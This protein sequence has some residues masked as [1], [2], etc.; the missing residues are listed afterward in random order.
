MAPVTGPEAAQR[1]GEVLTASDAERLIA[2]L[3]RR[4]PLSYAAQEVDPTRRV[5]AEQLC[6]SIIDDAPDRVSGTGQLVLVLHALVAALAREKT[7]TPVWTVPSGIGITGAAT[8][9]LADHVRGARASIVCSTFNLQ[10][11]SALVAALRA[12][13]PDSGVK[14]N[15]FVDTAAAEGKPWIGKNGQEVAPYTPEELVEALPGANVWRTRR[16]GDRVIR[17]HAKFVAIDH[18]KLVVTSANM[19][20]SA[21]RHNVELGL[22]AVDRLLTQQVERTLFEFRSSVYELVTL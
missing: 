7:V 5:A 3:R 19:S 4:K 14:I 13:D 2:A 6:R 20:R 16:V 11:S 1:L 21:E 18:Q 15:L 12:V 9:Q 8:S 17:N 22:V 10:R